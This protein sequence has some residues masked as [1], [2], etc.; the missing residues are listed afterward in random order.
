MQAK[1]DKET[2]DKNNPEL[3]EQHTAN[4]KKNHPESE[5]VSQLKSILLQNNY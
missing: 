4:F 2:L 3:V 5:K 1:I